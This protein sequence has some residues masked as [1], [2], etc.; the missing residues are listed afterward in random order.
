MPRGETPRIETSMENMDT[1]RETIEV[2]E[3]GKENSG[4]ATQNYHDISFGWHKSG[5]LFIHRHNRYF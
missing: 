4:R 3:E 5:D 1:R 2:E